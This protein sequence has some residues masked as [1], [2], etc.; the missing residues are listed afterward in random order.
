L[1]DDTPT[2]RLPTTPPPLPPTRP[3]RPSRGPMIAFIVL[4]VV[5]VMAM[6]ALA[7]ILVTKTTIGAAAPPSTAPPSASSTPSSTPSDP[8]APPQG[9][10]TAFQVPASQ[11]CGGHGR[12]HQQ[13][14]AQVTWA[15]ENSAQVWVAQGS[16]DALAARGEQVPLS[17]DQ[18]AFPHPLRLNC[19]SSSMTFTMTLIGDDGVHVSRTWTIAI[20]RSH[21]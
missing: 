8:P 2:K 1:S 6:G 13:T 17:G 16:Q 5:L 4:A 20:V 15:T 21:S 11:Q 3:R 7:W 12:R 10:F 9:A 18:D 14:N 19:D